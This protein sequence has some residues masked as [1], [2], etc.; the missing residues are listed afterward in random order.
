VELEP[1]S[2]LATRFTFETLYIYSATQVIVSDI[3]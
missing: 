2:P 3:Q 1:A